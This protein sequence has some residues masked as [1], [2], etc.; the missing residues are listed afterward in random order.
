MEEKKTN[1]FLTVGGLKTIL[2]E[3]PDEMFVVIPVVDE[4]DVNRIF[5]FRKVGTAGVL[6]NKSEAENERKVLC[7]NGASDGYDIADQVHFS[8]RDVSVTTVLYGKSNQITDFD[9]DTALAVLKDFSRD[10]YPSCDIF[11]RKTL[12]INRDEFEA[13]RKKFLDAEVK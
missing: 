10:M 5:G 3:L 1:D 12:V 9:R 2:E 4:D 11:G 7:V 6:E 8:G 13:I